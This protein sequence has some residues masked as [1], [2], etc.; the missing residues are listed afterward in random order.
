MGGLEVPISKPF[1]KSENDLLKFEDTNKK[2]NNQK[3]DLSRLT[4]STRE[5]SF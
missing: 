3:G 5:F 1:V 4:K 2:S